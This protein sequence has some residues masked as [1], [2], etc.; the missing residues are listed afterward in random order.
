MVFQLKFKN[1]T[2]LYFDLCDW[3]GVCI[4]SIG[5][6]GISRPSSASDKVVLS[7]FSTEPP[8]YDRNLQ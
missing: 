7:P 8:I 1:N 4:A 5:A 3:P 2:G 6:A